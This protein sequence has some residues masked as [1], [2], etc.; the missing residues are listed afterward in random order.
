MARIGLNTACVQHKGMQRIEEILKFA[1]E[2]GFSGIEF[3]DEYPLFEEMSSAEKTRARDFI[4]QH[5][6]FCSVHLP[7]ADMNISNFINILWEA[8]VRTLEDSLQN[9]AELGATTVT[10]HGGNINTLRYDELL[11]KVS[12]ERTVKALQRLRNSAVSLGIRLSI[13]NLHEF[14]SRLK[15]VHSR[16]E[17]LLRSRSAL[18]EDIG[19]TFDIGHAVSTPC[20]PVDFIHS[21]G[22]DKILLSH[23]HDNNGSE[24]Q[25]LAVGDGSIDF[26]SFIQAYVNEGWSFPLLIET[27]NPDQALLSRD[28]LL[29]LIESAE[30]KITSGGK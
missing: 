28:R 23:L 1:V 6:L 21:L 3:K 25:H 2:E 15:R 24:D 10:V 4:Q 26:T 7:F 29:A 14:S 12:E 8:A 13:E 18:G 17:D 20:K 5:G 19:F 16:P 22:P 11:Y 30:L 27:R 9:A